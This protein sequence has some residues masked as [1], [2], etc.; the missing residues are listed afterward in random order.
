MTENPEKRFYKHMSRLQDLTLLV[1]KGHL[2]IEEQL[3]YFLSKLARA[4]EHLKDARLSY[5]QKL[6]LVRALSG[7]GPDEVA[8]ARAINAIRNSLAHRLD[9][10][11][12]PDKI[13]ALLRQH[14]KGLPRKSSRRQLAAL[15]RAELA[16]VCGR[17]HGMADGFYWATQAM[18][19]SQRSTSVLPTER[20]GVDGPDRDG[21]NRKR[22]PRKHETPPATTESPDH[23]PMVV[24]GT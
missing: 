23:R 22:A 19:Q 14:K 2:L 16:F 11:D 1:L 24:P 7:M 4:P 17:F 3:G 20:Q 10:D 6:Q 8:F 9:A 18:M 15:L 12:L 13:D 21:Q 5:S